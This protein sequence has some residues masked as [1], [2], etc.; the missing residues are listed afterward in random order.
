MNPLL[1]IVIPT[2]NR[3]V[4]CLAAVQQIVKLNLPSVEIVVQDNSD[5]DYLSYSL[6]TPQM[7]AVHVRYTYEPGELSFVDN[8]SHGIENSCGEYVCMIG[9]DDGVLPSIHEVADYASRNN[10][11]AV[12]PALNS[13]YFWPNNQRVIKTGGG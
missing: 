1:S 9:D 6:N 7:N 11:D 10:L 12:I 2:R 8:F 4:Y 5:N 13:V 3:Q